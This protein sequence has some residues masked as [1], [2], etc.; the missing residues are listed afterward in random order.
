MDE[1][2]EKIEGSKLRKEN[3]VENMTS[4][5]KK[6]KKGGA[7]PFVHFLFVSLLKIIKLFFLSY[8]FFIVFSLLF[9]SHIRYII[10]II[11]KPYVDPI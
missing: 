6:N 1:H 2:K 3:L 7:T 10:T 8:F 5:E 9:I 11:F 4:K